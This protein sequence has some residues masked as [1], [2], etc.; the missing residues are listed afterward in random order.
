[1]KRILLLLVA[2]LAGMSAFAQNNIMTTLPVTLPGGVHQVVNPP[3]VQLHNN[4]GAALRTTSSVNHSD[5]FDYWNQNASTTSTLYSYYTYPDSNLVDN[6]STPAYNIYTHGMGMS[7]DPT[8]SHYFDSAVTSPITDPRIGDTTGYTIDSFRFPY[9]Y[10]RFDTVRGVDSLIVEFFV[11]TS[12]TTI[13]SGDYTLIF[14]SSSTFSG[15]TPDLT[16]RFATAKYTPIDASLG[17][18]ECWDSILAPKQRYAFPLTI[19]GSGTGIVYT[20]ESFG[21]TTPLAVPPGG[22]VISYIHFKSAHGFTLGTDISAANY[23]VLFA[24]TTASTST[25]WP[26]QSP[27]D[28]STGYTGSYQTGL[29]ATNQNRYSNYSTYT[30]AGHNILIPGVA[31][32]IPQLAVTQQAWHVNWTSFPPITGTLS[33]CVGSSTTL[34]DGATGGTWS[35]GST[36]VATVS[37]T[38][39]VYGVSA[40]TAVISYTVGS[41]STTA[42]V[43]VLG[44]PVTPT[45]TGGPDVC[46]GQSVTI[47]PSETGGTWSSTPATVA[48]IN[49]S[50]VVFGVSAGTAVISY[51]ITNICGS[52]AGSYVV[53]V[54]S[55]PVVAAI[56]GR[57][58]VCPS[59]ATTLTDATTGGTW[60]SLTPTVATVSATGVV[61]GVTNGNDVIGYVVTNSSCA[62]TAKLTMHVHCTTGVNT[63]T[64]NN[65]ENIAVYPNP[66]EGSF[67]LILNSPVDEQVT[68]VITNI[69]GQVVKEVTIA[70][71]KTANLQLN[72]PAGIYYVAATLSGGRYVQTVTIMK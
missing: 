33:V 8:D 6:T 62:D 70:T 2:G 1:M 53:T 14:S 34:S 5:W 47:T 28:A 25:T 45:F 42:T 24:G 11:T 55:A 17:Q 30:Y 56:S 27:H 29:I 37:S 15:I 60:I 32:S 61:T 21:L 35:S 48:T 7:F 64:T 58:T 39:V 3:I 16:P 52:S 67:S 71:N 41:S 4:D 54:N 69:T 13:D 44:T 31:F 18:S 22:K 23:L 10:A 26:E 38:G 49:S 68:V 43:T 57:D 40:G 66:N 51:S 12:S 50:G 20:T 36:S 19:A 72:E 46:T 65:D 63:V 59:L 9:E